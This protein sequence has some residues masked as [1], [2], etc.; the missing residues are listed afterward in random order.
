MCSFLL[1]YLFEEK[2]IVST[3]DIKI[4]SVRRITQNQ[5]R[6][7]TYNWEL[8][9]SHSYSGVYNKICTFEMQ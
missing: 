7:R 1:L 6:S 4:S 3:K 2:L 8:K 9:L 5:F